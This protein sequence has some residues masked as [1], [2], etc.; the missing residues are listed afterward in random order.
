MHSIS[1]IFLLFLVSFTPGL[2]QPTESPNVVFIAMDDLN[3][4][5]HALGYEQAIIPNLDRLAQAGVLFTNAHTAGSY[6][7]SSRTAIFTGLHA[8]TTG[9]YN[10]QPFRYDY[11]DLETLQMAF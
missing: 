4:W 11:P 5:V 1:I 3:D 2:A 9:C 7:T 10:N 6:C 8:S